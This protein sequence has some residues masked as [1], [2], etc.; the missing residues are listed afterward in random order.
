MDDSVGFDVGLRI[1]GSAAEE[2]LSVELLIGDGE[3]LVV[4]ALHD[5]DV[6]LALGLGDVGA[7]VGRR[8]LLGLLEKRGEVA[9][10]GIGLGEL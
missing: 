6:A 5:G 2:I 3:R 9:E 8:D 7:D 1:S 4:E 10:T